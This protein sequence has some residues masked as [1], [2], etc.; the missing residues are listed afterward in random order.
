M[1]RAISC[2]ALF[3]LPACG[4][5]APQAEQ[6]ATAAV[7]EQTRT[8]AAP[9]PAATPPAP[10]A[11]A[12][13][14]VEENDLLQ[15]RYTW[16]AQAAAIPKLDARL[17]VDARTRR[18][19]SLN[20]AKADRQE[21]VS[22]G[23]PFHPYASVKN[24]T[25]E[26]DTQRLLALRAEFYEFTGGAH[27][28]S[29]FDSILWDRS[30]DRDIAVTDLFSDKV[31]ALALLKQAF[32]PALNAE[33]AKRRGAPVASP[34]AD[35]SRPDDWMNACPDLTK[36][37]LIPSEV[38]SG[39]FT[40]I[41]VLIGPYEAGPYAEGTYDIALPVTPALAAQVRPDYA[42]IIAPGA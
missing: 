36:Q 4:P 24:W 3:L 23:F 31:E 28:I 22:Q 11:E 40:T 9:N 15:F 30:R 20:A 17:R 6:T 42:D 39:R 27:G 12:V 34:S 10:S 2:L 19:Q 37:V 29:G 25:V 1:V 33:R 16:P 8:A 21:R 7:E 18:Q 14:M 38:E 41:R 13:T 26:G 35:G 5:S 32:C